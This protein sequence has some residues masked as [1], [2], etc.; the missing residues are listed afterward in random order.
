MPV[1]VRHRG[2]HAEEKKAGLMRLRPMRSA[3]FL[4]LTLRAAE[5]PLPALRAV[6]ERLIVTIKLEPQVQAV[7]G[8]SLLRLTLVRSC[9]RAACSGRF[10]S[11]RRVQHGD[12][13]NSNGSLD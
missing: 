6:D 2:R 5:L 8:E 11:A 12:P 13:P 3:F 9:L 4:P 10:E 7:A 1:R